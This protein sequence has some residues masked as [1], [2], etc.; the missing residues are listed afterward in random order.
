M[1]LVAIRWPASPRSVLVVRPRSEFPRP[2]AT[3]LRAQ[4]VRNVLITPC[5]GRHAAEHG[6]VSATE[7][8]S[9]EEESRQDASATAERAEGRLRRRSALLLCFCVRSCVQFLFLLHFRPR[10]ERLTDW[11]ESLTGRSTRTRTGRL[12]PHD[13]EGVVVAA[14]AGFLPG[15]WSC[16][17]AG[18]PGAKARFLCAV[19]FRWTEVQLPLLKQ[20]APT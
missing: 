18:N 13:E 4:S 9:Q 17:W 3:P 1:G 5:D 16:E 7:R 6:S 2:F 10:G 20:G 12:K 15:G 8:R 19:L 14:E 11:A